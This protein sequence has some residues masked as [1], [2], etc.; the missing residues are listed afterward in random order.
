MRGAALLAGVLCLAMARDAGSRRA[1]ASGGAGCRDRIA[2]CREMIDSGTDSCEED[3]CD[4]CGNQRHRCDATCGF[5]TGDSGPSRAA[6]TAAQLAA[7]ASRSH[8]ATPAVMPPVISC[9]TTKLDEPT[10]RDHRCEGAVAGANSCFIN[11]ELRLAGCCFAPGTAPPGRRAAEC[12]AEQDGRVCHSRACNTPVAITSGPLTPRSSSTSP[13]RASSA[14]VDGNPMIGTY[15]DPNHPGGYRFVA[16]GADGIVS[17]SGNDHSTSDVEWTLAGRLV[18]ATAILID[19]TPKSAAVGS[20]TARFD[21]FQLLFP[22]GNKWTKQQQE[23]AGST[24]APLHTSTRDTVGAAENPRHVGANL[25]DTSG[26]SNFLN[27][28]VFVVGLLVVRCVYAKLHR[29][30]RAQNATTMLP[31]KVGTHTH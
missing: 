4:D 25:Q 29:R 16:I 18:D 26:S 6:A 20:V 5:C 14:T 28:Y 22:D 13:T 8:T 12:N 9:Y 17:V 7:A 31:M 21:G 11:M 24:G 19:F 1:A 3:F 30:W 23:S 10:I 27:L 2:G 15:S